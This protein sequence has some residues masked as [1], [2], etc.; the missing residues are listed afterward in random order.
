MLN[1]ERIALLPAGAIVVNTARGAIVDDE[2][3]VAALPGGQVACGGTGRIQR[4]AGGDP[5]GLT[6]NS[7]MFSYLPHLGSATE[8]TR[9]AMG[10]RALDNL[11]AIFAGREPADRVA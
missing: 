4:R 3:L 8:E 11:D 10:F 9:D 2:A 5:P 6:G 7:T 1:A